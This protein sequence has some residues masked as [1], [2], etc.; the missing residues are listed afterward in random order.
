MR[1]ANATFER[2][3]T[4]RATFDITEDGTLYISADNHGYAAGYLDPEVGSTCILRILPGTRSFDP[5][6]EVRLPDVLDGRDGRELVYWRDNR[7]F[8]SVK[9][10]DELTTQ[11]ADDPQG[12]ATSPP[13]TG[14]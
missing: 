6:Y 9:H 14:G 7:A 10:D 12:S 1:H 2:P 4:S 11:F 8:V 13:D 5:D 3:A